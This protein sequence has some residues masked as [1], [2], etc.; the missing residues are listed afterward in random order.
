MEMEIR[1]DIGGL[2][3]DKSVGMREEQ[4]SGVNE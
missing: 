4:S 3:P 2:C 1:R